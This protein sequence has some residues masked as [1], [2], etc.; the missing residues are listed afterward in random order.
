MEGT[1]AL[2][3]NIK[4]ERCWREFKPGSWCTTIDV[5]DFIV[6][7]SRPMTATRN[8]WPGRPSAPR[9]FGTSFSRISRRSRR[10]AC[11]PSTRRRPRRCWRTRPGYIDRDNEIIVG[12]QTDQP[13]KRAIF[14]V[15]RPAHGRG[16]PEGGRLRGRSAGARGLHE[17]PQVPQRR[18]VRRLY[19][20]NHAAA[21]GPASLPACRMPMA[22]AGSSATTGA[23]RSMASSAC[24]R[25]S[26][27]SAR[28]STTCGRPTRSSGRARNWP[29]RF[30]R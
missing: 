25:P 28:R 23:S 1:A 30:A 24:S 4:D 2:P 10:K 7:M 6:A 21:A 9:R 8:F 5:R 26:R 22:A 19:A 14:P 15:W 11:L 27:Q 20:G 29:T 12:L 17:I 18:R 13:F 3:K 16:G